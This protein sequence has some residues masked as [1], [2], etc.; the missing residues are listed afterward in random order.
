MAARLTAVRRS[1]G[2]PA[3][4]QVAE[5]QQQQHRVEVRRASHTQYTPQVGGPRSCRSRGVSAVK[6]MATSADGGGG[7]VP[8][9]RLLPEEHDAADA[10]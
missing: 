6:T 10:W 7:E 1:A 5:Q 4:R 9:P 3:H 8:P 2:M